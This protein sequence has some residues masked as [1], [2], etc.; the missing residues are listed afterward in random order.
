MNAWNTDADAIQISTQGWQNLIVANEEIKDF[1]SVG[2]GDRKFF[3]VAPKG[4]GKTLLLKAK[5]QKY[6]ESNVGSGYTFIPQTQLC[7]KMTKATANFT[8]QELNQYKNLDI[9]EEIWKLSLLILIIRNVKELSLPA[10]LSQ[11]IGKANTLSNILE[12]ILQNRNDLYLFLKLVPSELR[13]QVQQLHHQVA[14][15]IDNVDEAFD[16]HVGD[17]YR[18]HHD[19]FTDRET[20]SPSVWINAQLGL[21][22]AVKDICLP[23]KHIKIFVALRS[24]AYDRNQ[25]ATDYQNRTYTT[26]LDYSKNTLEDIFKTNIL[27][28][29]PMRLSNPEEDNLFEKFLGIQ[30]LPHV[31]VKYSSGEPIQEHIFNYI[32]RHTFTRPREIVGMGH[33]LS[34]LSNNER[35]L[36]KIRQRVNEESYRLLN[37]YKK[38]LIPYFRRDVYQAFCQEVSSNV[39]S[40][41]EA[42]RI[43]KKIKT[44]YGYDNLI[45]NLYKIGLLGC[46]E[47]GVYKDGYRQR[48]L[49]VANY[50]LES[51]IPQTSEFYLVHPSMDIDLGRAKGERIYN[52]YNIIGYDLPFHK[53]HDTQK[54]LHVHFGLS[55]LSRSLLLPILYENTQLAVIQCPDRETWGEITQHRKLEFVINNQESIELYV[56]HDGMGRNDVGNLIR[57]WKYGKRSLL[58]YTENERIIRQVLAHVQSLST[59]K[60]NG[61]IPNFADLLNDIPFDREIFMFPFEYTDKEMSALEDEFSKR[62]I[63]WEIVPIIADLFYYQKEIHEERSSIYIHC[64]SEGELYIQDL[65]R[66][67]KEIFPPHVVTRY[68]RDPKVLSFYRDRHRFLSDATFRLCK[69]YQNYSKNALSSDEFTQI[70]SIFCQM[71]AERLVAITSHKVLEQAYT[72]ANTSERIHILTRYGMRMVSRFEQLPEAYTKITRLEPYQ[73][74][75]LQK[76]AMPTVSEFDHYFLKSDVDY[77]LLWKLRQVLGLP[78]NKNYRSVFISYSTKDDAFATQVHDALSAFGVE[79]FKFDVDAA[80]GD[81]LTAIMQGGIRSRDRLLFIA[82]KRSIISDYCQYELTQIREKQEAMWDRMLITVRID[83]FLLELNEIDIPVS[84]RD[85]VL[86]N[87]HM[88]K[89]HYL[90]DWSPYLDGENREGFQEAI[91][92]MIVRSLKR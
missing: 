84:K 73:K 17:S 28:T 82:S 15:F 27:Q 79:T 90:T 76:K 35:T 48:F 1:L 68:M 58:L 50:S 44:E 29:S 85:T 25:K 34:K 55:R 6:R 30:Y 4:F 59:S 11:L 13:P 23:N 40:Y 81:V 32:Y 56:I 43:E 78:P 49:K 16:A 9:W 65:G 19:H 45:E 47:R 61:D 3:I 10:P 77:R 8:T 26:K 14:V 64:E 22:Q 12:I 72:Q 52:S 60:A 69:I 86:P 36:S 57:E 21:I 38:E 7:E 75:V 31:S 87:I 70:L 20:L 24:E 71:Q 42:L 91:K 92:D 41:R 74:K 37:Q 5:S 67:V 39:F 2:Q 53:D 88:L 62:E 54:K 66:E 51:M 63:N 80:E 89:E 83:K 33:A 18:D 46:V